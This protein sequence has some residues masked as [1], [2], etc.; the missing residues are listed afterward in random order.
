MDVLLCLETNG[1]ISPGFPTSLDCFFVRPGL[2]SLVFNLVET[3]I[4]VA[5]KSSVLNTLANGDWH[6]VT[7]K[8]A[9]TARR[10]KL[11]AILHPGFIETSPLRKLILSKCFKAETAPH[12]SRY[13]NVG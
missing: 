10:S 12:Y 11:A 1:G 9:E 6:L 8:I 13:Y 5:R 2:A 4:T 3:A 7:G